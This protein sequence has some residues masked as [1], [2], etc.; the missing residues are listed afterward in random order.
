MAAL[1]PDVVRHKLTSLTHSRST[2]SQRTRVFGLALLTTTAGRSASAAEAAT[3]CVRLVRKVSCPMSGASTSFKTC[4]TSTA[5]LPQTHCTGWRR[6]SGC[7]GGRT[8]SSWHRRGT[9]GTGTKRLSGKCAAIE[10][11][12]PRALHGMWLIDSDPRSRIQ[13]GALQTYSLRGRVCLLRCSCGIRRV[14]CTPHTS[15]SC[16]QFI[17]WPLAR[18]SSPKQRRLT[19]LV[20]SRFCVSATDTVQQK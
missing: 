17:Q 8:G 4:T 15:C 19:W 2:S 5:L 14:L 13:A 16:T 1:L 10:A 7:R 6:C 20:K 12:D 11:A 9:A 18:S 3:T